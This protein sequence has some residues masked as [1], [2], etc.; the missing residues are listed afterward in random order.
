MPYGGFS[1]RT[2][3][4]E[5][6]EKKAGDEGIGSRDLATMRETSRRVVD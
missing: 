1:R 2:S 6:E 5:I 4:V 3:G